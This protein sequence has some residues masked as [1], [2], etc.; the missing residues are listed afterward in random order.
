MVKITDSP[1]I[2]TSKLLAELENDSF[3]SVME[4]LHNDYGPNAFRY[5]FAYVTTENGKTYPVPVNF[6]DE[7]EESFQGDIPALFPEVPGRLVCRNTF[8]F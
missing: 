1:N 3:Q 4:T 7:N 8:A 2:E 5:G 6:R